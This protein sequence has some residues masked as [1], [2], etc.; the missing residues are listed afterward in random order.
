M[1]TKNLYLVIL[2]LGIVVILNT[3]L[4]HDAS[5][6]L[7][8][9]NL[10]KEVIRQEIYAELDSMAWNYDIDANRRYVLNKDHV[11]RCG[12]IAEELQRRK[13]KYYENP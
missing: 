2:T 1:S 10:D 8:I 3:W 6:Q 13:N 7:K 5:E 4:L 9:Y 12:V 11:F